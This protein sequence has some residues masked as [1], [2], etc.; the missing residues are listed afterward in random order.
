MAHAVSIATVLPIQMPHICNLLSI[1]LVLNSHLS[2]ISPSEKHSQNFNVKA[3]S[4]EITAT[5]AAEANSFF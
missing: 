4:E 1:H 2:G 5:H 3:H